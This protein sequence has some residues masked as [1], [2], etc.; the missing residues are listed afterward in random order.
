M[1]NTELELQQLG[2]AWVKTMV[3]SLTNRAGLL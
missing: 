1:D 2:Q 3:K